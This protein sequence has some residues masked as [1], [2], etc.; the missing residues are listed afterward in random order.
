MTE[1]DFFEDPT[2]KDPDSE[3]EARYSWDEEF[4]RH[5]IS[6]L[7]C[8]RQFLLQSVDLIRPSYFTNKAHTK[9]CS[10][11]FDHFREYKK[12]PDKTIILQ[13]MKDDLK[14]NK[15]LPYYLGEMN[16]LF[17]YFKPGLDNR[18]YLLD[19]ITNFAKIQAIRQAFNKS[20]QKIQEDPENEK[21]WDSVYDILQNAMRVD[22]NFDIGTNYFTNLHER[23]ARMDDDE[24]VRDIFP[25]GFESVDRELKYGGYRRGELFAVC[26]DSGVGKSVY[27]A[28]MTA[29]NLLRGHKGLYVS[30]E[31]DEE[32][33]EDRLDA[34]LTGMPVQRLND[35]KGEIF[36]MLEGRK[37][38]M[39]NDEPYFFHPDDTENTLLVKAFPAGQLTVNMLQAY[40]DQIRFHGYAPDFIIVDYIGEMKMA[41]HLKT[42]EAMEVVA[43]D[44]RGLAK[45]E[46][47]FIATALQPNRAAK[48]VQQHGHIGQQ[49]LA[50][51][52]GVIRPMDGVVMFNQNDTESD[53][54]IGR[55]WVE[56]NRKARKHY[57]FY[58]NFDKENLQITEITHD[59]YRD[60]RSKKEDA[61]HSEIEKDQM[62]DLDSNKVDRAKNA[63]KPSDEQGEDTKDE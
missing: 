18:D 40:I 35:F 37:P 52:F 23:Y 55:G 21:T 30:C 29:T 2:L 10:I 56:K 36:D 50:D 4:Q 15:S 27:L 45:M 31:I 47:V 43:R 25:T 13:E 11:L 17:K 48:E 62:K 6:L 12:M 3:S 44:L 33:I 32:E 1:H 8:D 58:L 24:N 53:L 20:L 26:S 51:A 46:D 19:K 28:C 61:V 60:R 49:H 39:R 9:A 63:Y 5:I 42:Y 14:D 22:R 16:S 34:I 57:Y 59:E 41:S 54:R 38:I 7:L